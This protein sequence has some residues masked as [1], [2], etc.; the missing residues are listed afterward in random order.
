MTQWLSDLRRAQ[1]CPAAAALII[2][3]RTTSGTLLFLHIQFNISS[4]RWS[5]V[6]DVEKLSSDFFKH[7]KGKKFETKQ[8]HW[9]KFTTFQTWPEFFTRP[10]STLSACER[11]TDCWWLQAE[12]RKTTFLNCRCQT[13][14]QHLNLNSDISHLSRTG[15]DVWSDAKP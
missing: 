1:W 13:A 8:Q 7:R 10:S 12:T 6:R 5:E 14:F 2:S 11:F 4:L 15:A 3:H 9:N